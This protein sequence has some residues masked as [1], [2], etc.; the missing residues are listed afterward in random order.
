MNVTLP[1]PPSCNR[2]WRTYHGK[3]VLA[4]EA[5]VYKTVLGLQLNQC[6]PVADDVRDRLNEAGIAITDTAAGPEWSLQE[7]N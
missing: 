3:T 4:P 7:E 5:S 6:Q 2:I 1:Y